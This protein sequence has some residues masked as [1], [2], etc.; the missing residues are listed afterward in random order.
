MLYFMIDKTKLGQ[1]MGTAGL[2]TGLVYSIHKNKSFGA[3]AFYTLAFGVAGVMVGNA[4]TKFYEN[5]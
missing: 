4:V 2:I 3:G 1:I 5:G